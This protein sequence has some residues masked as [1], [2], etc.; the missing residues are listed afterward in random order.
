M[1]GCSIISDSEV[2]CTSNTPWFY[3]YDI[4]NGEITRHPFLK[5]AT[6]NHKMTR[7]YSNRNSDFIA[8]PTALGG[9]SIISSKFKNVFEWFI[10]GHHKNIFE[11]HSSCIFIKSNFIWT[12]ASLSVFLR[13]FVPRDNKISDFWRRKLNCEKGFLDQGDGYSSA[14]KL[15]EVTQYSLQ[16]RF[17]FTSSEF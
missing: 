17:Y 1:V 14:A 5:G 10:N 16:S 7:F 12:M 13:S 3:S 6:R 15:F 11:K 8:F 2:L 4:I 9:I